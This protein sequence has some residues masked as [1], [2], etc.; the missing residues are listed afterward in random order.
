MVLDDAEIAFLI[1]SG[2]MLTLFILIFYKL[3]KISNISRGH[4]ITYAMVFSGLMVVGFISIFIFQLI[5]DWTE[6]LI[7]NIVWIP[8][9]ILMLQDI[10]GNPEVRRIPFGLAILSA[11]LV[12]LVVFGGVFILGGLLWYLSRE[13]W[14]FPFPIF[15]TIILAMGPLLILA[16][17][18]FRKGGEQ[19]Y[20]RQIPSG[21]RILLFSIGAVFG[22]ALIVWGL[23][24]FIFGNDYDV[25][26]PQVGVVLLSI[27]IILFLYSFIRT[28][29]ERNK[30][31]KAGII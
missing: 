16:M 28:I 30:L 2:I 29:Q 10:A 3:Y 5:V 23:A 18:V 24:P 31:K 19:Y 14:L 12:T 7:F 21:G 27:G 6:V 17:R 1:S 9:F 15:L 11:I 20:D 25:V 26:S 22:I 4:K 13:E 8:F